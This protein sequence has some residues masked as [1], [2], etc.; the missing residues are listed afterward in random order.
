MVKDLL[1]DVIKSIQAVLN[2]KKEITHHA[3]LARKECS[4]ETMV[5]A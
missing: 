1:K 4:L 5:N 2:A 3:K